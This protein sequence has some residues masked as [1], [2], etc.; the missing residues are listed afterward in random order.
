MSNY[1]DELKWRGMFQNATP[2]VEALLS[3]GSKV[4]YTGFDP[5]AD[6]LHLGNMVAIMMLVH[7]Q[8]MGHKPIALVGGATGMIGDPSGKSAERNLLDLEELRHN[9]D[10]IKKQLE[11]FL[12][13]KGENAAKL[14]NNYDWFQG[15]GFL[16]FIRNTGK[17]I[18]VNYMM[19]KD[20][21]KNRLETGISFTEFTYQ[22]IQGYDFLHLYQNEDCVLQM[23]GSD[24]WGNITTG[25]EL[26]RRVAGGEAHA[27]TCPLMTKSDGTKFGKSE[28]GNV[29]LDA[30]KT[31]PYQ[32]YQF[33]LRTAD[34]DAEK[35]IK[36]LSLKSKDEILGIIAEHNENPGARALQKALAEEL[37]IRVH[38]Q[39][40]LDQAV[41]ASGILFGKSTSDDLKSLSERA[42]LEVFEGVPQAEIDRARLGEID[43]IELFSDES[44]FL[45]SKG[46]AR[47]AFK[48]N[49]LSLNKE[50][51][52]EDFK[53][54]ESILLNNKYVLLQR[55]K[56]NYFL[57]VVK[58]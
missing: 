40:D 12:D 41:K 20:S 27:I 23:G 58:N 30:E 24:Q 8:R 42:F 25:T 33:L 48:E 43:A 47:R 50:K 28:Q 26:I 35:L 38:S 18:S 14:V 51:I 29:W 32:F 55:G 17:H 1:V 9:Q 37:T 44:G 34:E 31:S 56:K 16:E 19:A 54:D 15:M 39:E 10:C 5:S 21:V 7:F 52:K 2:D 57:V 13:F 36:I 22:L 45:K 6:S 4:G 3:K 11:K 49:S 46:E 53:V